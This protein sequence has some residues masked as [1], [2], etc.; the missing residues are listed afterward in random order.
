MKRLIL[1]LILVLSLLLCACG[2]TA[3]PEKNVTQDT[4]QQMPELENMSVVPYE[5][6]TM[7]LNFIEALPAGAVVEVWNN[8]LL[9]LTHTVD[10]PALTL[11]FVNEELRPDVNYSLKVNGVLQQHSGMVAGR[12]DA[13]APPPE[14]IPDPTQP[15][16]PEAPAGENQDGFTPGDGGSTGGPVISEGGPPEPSPVEPIGTLPVEIPEFSVGAEIPAFSELPSEGFQPGQ[17]PNM[18]NLTEFRL[19]G[20]VT[21][22]YSVCPAN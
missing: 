7:E 5:H 13:I 8:D 20:G 16:I 21:A 22:F 18:P 10:A 14:E 11:R 4:T 19:R 1:P 2:E 12:P 15:A 17:A 9:V 6:C 3:E